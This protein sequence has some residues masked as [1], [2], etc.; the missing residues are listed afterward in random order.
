MI[1]VMRHIVEIPRFHS[2]GKTVRSMAPSQSAE[3]VLLAAKREGS[4]FNMLDTETLAA[5]MDTAFYTF[6]VDDNEELFSKIGRWY[7]GDDLELFT[8]AFKHLQ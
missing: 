6:S 8:E 4:K 1:N 2:M 3:M 7:D 5:V